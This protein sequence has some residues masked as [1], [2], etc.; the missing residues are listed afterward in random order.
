MTGTTFIAIWQINFL[1]CRKISGQT[2]QKGNKT[3]SKEDKEV[4]T[5]HLFINGWLAGEN[6]LPVDKTESKARGK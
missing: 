5:K 6:Q 4:C 1:S 2:E 3:I